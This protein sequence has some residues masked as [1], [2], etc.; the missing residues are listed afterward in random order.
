MRY[1]IHNEMKKKTSPIG[2][3]AWVFAGALAAYLY[4]LWMGQID[5]E[6]RSRI[7]TSFDLQRLVSGIGAY[8]REYGRYPVPSNAQNS[9]VDQRM[10]FTGELMDCLL[11]KNVEGLNPRH[12]LFDDFLEGIGNRPGLIGGGTEPQ[13]PVLDRWGHPYIVVMD[14]NE[15]GKLDN[16]DA[17]SAILLVRQ[18]ASPT[19]DLGVLALCRGPDGMEGTADD[20]PSWRQ[21]IQVPYENA[22][23]L[24]Q[25]FGFAGPMLGL[26]GFGVI[27]LA[28]LVR[29]GVGCLG[30]KIC[31]V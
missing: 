25:R 24:V 9:K 22:W 26:A 17:R 2:R 3:L 7:R 28:L 30:R 14:T 27:Q 6:Y 23:Y 16:P 15:D 11:G 4:S 31:K 13:K 29:D 20:I 8:H 18:T 1:K 12:V 21:H 10:E 5:M 19:L